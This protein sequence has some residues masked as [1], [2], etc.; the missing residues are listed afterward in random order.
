MNDESVML[1][2]K[3]LV[4]GEPIT[5]ELIRAIRYLMRQNQRLTES[6][7]RWAETA[8]RNALQEVKP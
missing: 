6:S 7:I 5:D 1:M 2:G 3:P 4:A 8:A